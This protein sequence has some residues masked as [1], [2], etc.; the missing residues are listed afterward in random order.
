ML[1]REGEPADKFFLIRRGMVSL[2]IDSPGRGTLLIETLEGGR[3]RRLVVAVRAVPLGDGRARNRGLPRG[4][5]RWRLPARQ[6]RVGSHARLPP[7]EALRRQPAR[8]PAIDPAPAA[9]CLRKCSQPR[10]ELLGAGP[11][12]PVPFEVVAKRQDTADVWTLELESCA[13]EPLEFQPG[14]F[15][16]LA[17]GGAGEVPISISGDADSPGRLV[18]TVRAVGLATEADVRGGA[19]AKCSACA[20]RSAGRGPST[21]RRRGRRDRRGR[22]RPAAV[23]SCDPAPAV[24]AASATGA[25]CCSTAAAAR[26]SCCSSTSSTRGRDEASRCTSPST[27]PGRTGSVTSA[28]SRG[29]CAALELEPDGVVAMSCGPEVMMRF[30]AAALAEQGVGHE[31]LYASMERNMQCGIG[32]CGHCQLGPTLVCRDGPVYRWS[33][34]E[35]WLAIREL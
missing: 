35:R 4:R 32:H 31:Q 26:T 15:T 30:L 1:L 23:A 9:R 18:H 29:S 8:P 16:M 7:D 14:Q 3:R 28:S 10:L 13:G 21:A 17:A 2:E 33:A 27:R 25:W 12:V 22:P 5:V 20:A 34:L 19:R 6:V 24:R 11:M